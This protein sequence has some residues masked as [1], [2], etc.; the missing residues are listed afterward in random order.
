[1]GR[2]RGHSPQNCAPHRASS[3]YHHDPVSNLSSSSMGWI[4]GYLLLGSFT[5]FSGIQP[6]PVIT[7]VHAKIT[8][9][10]LGVITAENPLN[11][12]AS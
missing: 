4:L 6:P 5:G 9:G 8:K 10:Y 2:P 11:G 7:P 3:E 12:C 1:M